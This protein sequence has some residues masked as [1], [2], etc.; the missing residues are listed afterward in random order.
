MG[1]KKLLIALLG[2]A[3]LLGACGSNDA[4]DSS[5]ND[6]NDS[7]DAVNGEKIYLANC[8]GCHGE[9][10]GGAAGPPIAGLKV[11]DILTAIEEGPG[12]MP[13]KLVSGQDAEA[14][15]NWISRQKK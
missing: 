7:L 12:T 9:N 8:S 5:N 13:A 11:S 10:L 6:G 2:A 3:F 15:A 14:V 4:V 1:L